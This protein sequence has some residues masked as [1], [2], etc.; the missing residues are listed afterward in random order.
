MEQWIPAFAGMTE[1]GSTCLIPT[2]LSDLPMTSR[3]A[4]PTSFAVPIRGRTRPL[5]GLRKVLT[6]SQVVA[7][8]FAVALVLFA[9]TAEA[10][11]GMGGSFGSR[12]LRTWSAP[13]VT[14]TAPGFASPIQRSITPQPGFGRTAPLGSPYGMPYSGGWF[15]RGFMGGLFGGLL[16]A[17]LFGMLFGNG[18]FGGIGGFGSL[19]GLI[20]QFGLIFLVVRWVMRSFGARNVY[21]TGPTGDWPQDHRGTG[22]RYGY[23]APPAGRTDRPSQ[24]GHD[25]AADYSLNRGNHDELG[26]AVADFNEFEKLLGEIQTA[27]GREDLAT[28]RR[29]LTP[30]MLNEAA[31][32]LTRNA[33]RGVVNRLSDVKLLHGDLA[34]AWREGDSDYATV[35]MRYAVRDV[36]EER[37]GGRVVETGPSEVTELWTFRRIGG[38]R[39]LLSAIQQA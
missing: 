20:L 1:N 35:A 31:E 24:L 34:E 7:A 6:R 9:G 29:L 27:H 18:F 14:E 15:G 36:T 4:L 32:E 37:D 5:E 8:V 26:L 10:R 11:F 17:G 28:L 2:R 19:F 23:D 13:P 38:G 22:A 3:A 25:A 30:E 39:W 12:G 21:A 33:S 16:G